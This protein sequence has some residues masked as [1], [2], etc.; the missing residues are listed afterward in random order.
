MVL[1]WIKQ[2]NS[3]FWPDVPS[4]PNLSASLASSYCIIAFPSGILFNQ[5]YYRPVQVGE[6]K[7]QLL[8]GT[9]EYRSGSEKRVR[10][11]SCKLYTNYGEDKWMEVRL[12][13]GEP[14]T[15]QFFQYHGKVGLVDC[16]V[17]VLY[18]IGD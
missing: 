18:R 14:F 6:K 5:Q 2:G 16:H 1:E 10:D 11:S 3:F 15:F 4:H 7:G 9:Y 13:Y 17:G 12:P 8:P